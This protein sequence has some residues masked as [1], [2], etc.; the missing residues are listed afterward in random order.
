[1]AS[2]IDYPDTIID[3]VS[4]FIHIIICIIPLSYSNNRLSAL[5]FIFD[6]WVMF[7]FLLWDCWW[8]S[9]LM[10]MT[11]RCWRASSLVVPEFPV[12]W[13]VVESVVFVV[14]FFLGHC[15][16]VDKCVWVGLNICCLGLWGWVEVM[17]IWFA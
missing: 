5:L 2:I 17:L 1:L 7:F 6:A 9:S 13:L 11:C 14:R 12:V 3:Y 15:W 10:F 16:S 8:C 4:N